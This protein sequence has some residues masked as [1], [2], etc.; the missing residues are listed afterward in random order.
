MHTV[1]ARWAV[2]LS[3]IGALV[4]PAAA[5][6]A[7]AQPAA[8]PKQDLVL[9]VD[10]SSSMA[11]SDP[12]QLRGVAGCLILDAVEIASDVRAGLVNFSTQVTTLPFQDTDHIR[13]RLGPKQLPAPDGGTNMEEALNQAVA[14]FA[15]STADIKRIVLITDG[16]PDSPGGI[17]TNIMP[18]AKQA[19][20]E[21]F[22]LGF[23]AGVDKNFLDQLTT[24]TGGRTLVTPNQERLLQSAKELVGDLDSIFNLKNQHLA[25]SEMSYDFDLPAGADRA[26]ATIILDQPQAF[27]T[28]DIQF[29]LQGPPGSAG[30]P[31]VARDSHG[32]DRV[33]AWTTFFSTPGH[34]T[35]KVTM[36]KPGGHLGLQFFAEALSS[37]HVELFPNP[38]KS[39][40]QTGEQFRVDVK[41]STGNGALTGANIVSFVKTPSGGTQPVAFANM[42]GVVTPSVIGRQTLVVRVVTPLAH[43]EAH[44]DFDVVGLPP[45]K[46]ESDLP[47]LKLTPLGAAHPSA[48]ATFHLT[49]I[50]P[51]GVA[52]HAIPFS[53]TVL[54]PVGTAELLAGTTRYAPGAAVYMLPPKGL[55]LTLNV[56]IDPNKSVPS[57]GMKFEEAINFTS[58]EATSFS[59]PF[60]GIFQKPK[61]ELLGKLTDVTLWWD[62]HRPRTVRLGRVHS[63]LS[64]TSTF[65]VIIPA[66][67]SDKGAKIADLTLSAGGID[68]ADP[69]AIDN[70][71]LRYGPIDLPPGSGVPLELV[72]TPDVNDGWE[73]QRSNSE[74]DVRLQSSLGMVETATPH[75]RSAGGVNLPIARQT[76]M[77]GRNLITGLWLGLF[78]AILAL[79]IWVNG[80]KVLRF[81]RVRPGQIIRLD[82]GDILLGGSGA[83][84]GAALMLPSVCVPD[85]VRTMGEV[86]LRAGRQRL[87]TSIPDMVVSPD[88]SPGDTIT[89]PDAPDLVGDTWL[90][91]YVGYDPELGGEVE[92]IESPR[93]WTPGR[94]LRWLLCGLAVLWTGKFL[95]GTA[96]AARIAYFFPFIESW[97]YAR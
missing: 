46:L 74:I 82:A 22:A 58:A 37:M 2:A 95:L 47:R 96:L 73:L 63:D 89:I 1:L 91:E 83:G 48:Q 17:L 15:G 67:I 85:E 64:D 8:I 38:S 12:M 50:F 80:R 93:Q 75:F 3:L 21:I 76:V 16:V 62:P 43:G 60:E 65:R 40:Y 33:V 51:A 79:V 7:A 78:G 6:T 28:E 57:A 61:F 87:E 13:Q 11:Q 42:Q 71:R 77:S 18:H 86:S 41:A 30:E 81:W 34:Y 29:D 94:L 26:R 23:S 49:P 90:V 5:Q 32:D 88:L 19:G 69:E 25:T 10:N 66:A 24:P 45:A 52:P 14:M 39:T 97:F 53:F 70:G 9:V 4:L 54:S 84:G 31:Y 59:L 56:K 35:F 36:P 20:I 68:L 55:A 92:V 72:V 27:K 44:F